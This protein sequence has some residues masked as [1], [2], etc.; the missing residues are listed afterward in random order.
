MEIK[1]ELRSMME[2]WRPMTDE[3]LEVAM[4]QKVVVAVMGRVSAG[5]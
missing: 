5:V 4:R 1:P 2:S 3:E